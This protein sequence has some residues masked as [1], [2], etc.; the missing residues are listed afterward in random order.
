MLDYEQ[1][2]LQMKNKLS[3]NETTTPVLS[4]RGARRAA[5]SPAPQGSAVRVSTVWI[6]LSNPQTR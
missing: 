3:A 6:G 1:R 4:A 5:L 2:Q